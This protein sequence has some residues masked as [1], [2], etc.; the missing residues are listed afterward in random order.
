MTARQ[1]T[2]TEEVIALYNDQKMSTVA[3]GQRYGIHPTLV[4][5]RLKRAGVPLRK[6]GPQLSPSRPSAEEL[7]HVYNVLNFTQGQGAAKY[8]VPVNEFKHWL[9]VAGI[10]KRKQNDSCDAIEPGSRA[11]T[12]P[13]ADELR[14]L[15][16]DENMSRKRI[17]MIYDVPESTVKSWC[18]S[19][20]LIGVRASQRKETLAK[21]AAEAP[22]RVAVQEPKPCPI[23]PTTKET[24][25]AEEAAVYLVKAR[26]LPTEKLHTVKAI[27]AQVVEY[28]R[29]GWRI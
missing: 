29:T 20:D 22:V 1:T 12:K 9:H 27:I 26:E 3:I 4:A 23:A 5:R 14:R 24:F 15:L 8:G 13:D 17:G 16:L 6:Q 21:V 25:T 19:A 10:T 18:R 11:G 2:E 7:D 28:K